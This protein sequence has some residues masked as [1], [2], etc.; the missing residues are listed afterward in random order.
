LV[1]EAFADYPFVPTDGG[2]ARRFLEELD[3]SDRAKI[4]SGNW[5]RLCAGI[6]R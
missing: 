5:D 3:D 6:R 4:A 1:R 2:V